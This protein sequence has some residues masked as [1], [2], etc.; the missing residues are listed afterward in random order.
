MNRIGKRENL[1][2]WVIFVLNWSFKFVMMN[3]LEFKY[4]EYKVKFNVNV[5]FI[6]I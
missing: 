2:R 6:Y 1:L 3:D 5:L 4:E